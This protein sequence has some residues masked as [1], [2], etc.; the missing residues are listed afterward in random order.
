MDALGFQRGF[1]VEGTELAGTLELD[2]PENPFRAGVVSEMVDRDGGSLLES[3]G[4]A[5]RPGVDYERDSD[6]SA[7]AMAPVRAFPELSKLKQWLGGLRCFR[8]DPF[9]IG[10]RSDGEAPIPDYNLSDLASWYRHLVQSSPKETQPS[11]TAWQM[12]PT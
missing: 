12:Q 2:L 11:S 3:A 4:S 5:S 10:S 6:R 1:V 9:A 7:L 8:I